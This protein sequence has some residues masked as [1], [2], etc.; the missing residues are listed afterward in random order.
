MKFKNDPAP[1]DAPPHTGEMKVSV[2]VLT[3]NQ[4][5]FIAQAIRS[6]LMQETDFAYEIIVG[7][8]ASTDRTGAIVA[9]LEQLHPDKVRVR[10][11]NAEVAQR[12][13]AVGVGGKGNF[14]NCLRT[15]T[16]KYIA[17]LDGDDYWTNPH[18]LQKQVDFLDRHP[19]FAISFHRVRAVKDAP[20]EEPEKHDQHLSEVLTVEDLL[21]ANPISA[22]S[23][24]FRRG[25]F[26]ELSR[27]FHS[28][29]L[30]DWALHVMNAKHGK[31]GC[32]N[33]VMAAYRINPAGLW[34]SLGPIEQRLEMIKV[35]NYIDAYLD[36]K[37]KEQIRAAK[38]GWYNQLVWI[39]KQR[40]ERIK[41]ANFLAHYIWLEGFKGA[42]RVAGSFFRQATTSPDT[43]L[44]LGPRV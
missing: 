10:W 5:K 25:L 40:G 1:H 4:E 28:L 24:M 14:V 37:Y 13:R 3:Y 19:D 34:S 21:V 16:A 41:L 44:Q 38:A 43:D 17:L 39:A 33:E 30:G 36:F 23:V 20:F 2:I 18:K 15:S 26:G 32:I 31:I 8:D 42:R 9:E 35:L 7:E 6:A 11:R 12:E 22:C 27:W 29:R